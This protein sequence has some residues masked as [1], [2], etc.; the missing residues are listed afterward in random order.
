VKKFEIEYSMDGN[1]WESASKGNQIGFNLII[2]LE[3]EGDNF[4]ARFVRLI[5][6]KAYYP[7]ISEFLLFPPTNH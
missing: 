4:K 7:T 2:D 6:T 1:N 5:I 3:E